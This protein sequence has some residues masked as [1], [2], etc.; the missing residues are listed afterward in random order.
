MTLVFAYLFK[1]YQQNSISFLIETTYLD[2]NTTFPAVSVCQQS[3]MNIS[4]LDHSK[5]DE[6]DKLPAIEYFITDLLF[7]A[8]TCYSCTLTHCFTCPLLNISE[9]VQKLRKPCKEILGECRWNDEKFNCCEYF[10]PL[11]TEYGICFSFNSLQ[12]VNQ[13]KNKLNLQMNRRTGTGRLSVELLED[14][15]LQFHA[16]EDVPFINAETNYIKEILHG[17]TYEILFNVM[18]LVNDDRIVNLPVNKRKCRFPWEVPPNLKVHKL[19]SYS[20]CLVQCHAE[21]HIN[22]CNCTHH[23]MPYYNKL[24]YCDVKGLN[25]LSAHIET[26]NRLHAKGSE[27]LGLDCDCVPSCTEPEYTSVSVHRLYNQTIGGAFIEMQSL[28]TSR[29]KRVVVKDALDLVVAV[30]GAAG[31]FIGASLQ[32]IVELVY[33]FFIKI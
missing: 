33:I 4:R 11:E 19:Y 15:R 29:F 27:R 14:V 26:V 6:R 22:I 25:C 30:G 7:F 32:T 18:E 21:N 28:P 31:L 9:I 2:W 12:T 20:T 23:H 24:N 5:F 10:L 3:G 1:S 16:P 8:G 13:P 17:E